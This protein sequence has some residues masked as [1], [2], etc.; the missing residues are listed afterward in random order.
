MKIPLIALLVFAA[1]SFVAAAEPTER[2]V[3][4][5]FG[6]KRDF[7]PV[8]SLLRQGWTVKHV[9]TCGENGDVLFVMRLP[10]G[11]VDI[12]PATTAKTAGE[13]ELAERR[14][15]FEKRRDEY[16]RAKGAKVEK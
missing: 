7:G 15:A 13:R 16:L 10:R 3:V 5:Q 6:W 8:H 2:L 4:V 1:T 11:E 12:D 9:M 14:A